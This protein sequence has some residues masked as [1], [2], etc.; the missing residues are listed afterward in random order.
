MSDLV[1]QTV[2]KVS[3]LSFICQQ[4]GFPHERGITSIQ[5]R[6]EYCQVWVAILVKTQFTFGSL[7]V[8]PYFLD[9]TLVSFI[10]SLVDFCFH[11][12]EKLWEM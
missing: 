11:I 4:G 5:S 10:K 8:H 6:T 9:M 7:L 3:A 12:P 2:V 1:Y